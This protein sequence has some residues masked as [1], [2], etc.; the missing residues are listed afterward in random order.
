MSTAYKFY[1]GNMRQQKLES[2]K[3]AGMKVLALVGLIAVLALLTWGSVH[4]ARFISNH[5]A[6][7]FGNLTSTV[8]NIMGLSSST[9]DTNAPEA[10]KAITF[11]LATNQ[12]TSGKAFTFSWDARDEEDTYFFSYACSDGVKF[13]VP[14]ELDQSKAI[15]CDT[16]FDFINTMNTLALT[17]V[18]PHNRFIDVPVTIGLTRASGEVAQGETLITIV[19]EDVMDSRSSREENGG[20]AKEVTL[21]PAETANSGV[22]PVAPAASQPS[23]EIRTFGGTVP[24]TRTTVSDPNGFFDLSIRVVDVGFI[25]SDTKAFIASSSVERGEHEGAIR[26]EVSNNGTKTSPKWMFEASLPT[27]PSYDYESRKQQALRPGERIEYTLA[28]D[29][30]RN[31]DK[32]TIVINIDPEKL[33]DEIVRSNNDAKAT[34]TIIR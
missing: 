5:A 19:N 32:G 7:G 29:R 17:P 34:I 26:F 2:L 8:A 25:D 13:D 10:T 33:L 9:G 27:T 31:A 15:P 3:A 22:V 30:V 1:M 12:A 18:S 4:G 24:T 23:R 16:R 6:G 11:T 28:F 20:N 14:G 21:A